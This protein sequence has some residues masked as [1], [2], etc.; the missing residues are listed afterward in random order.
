MTKQSTMRQYEEALL[1]LLGKYKGH[2]RTLQEQ[3]THYIYK[4]FKG[5]SKTTSKVYSFARAL[6]KHVC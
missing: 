4:Y 3:L 1:A 6:D 5:T 2:R